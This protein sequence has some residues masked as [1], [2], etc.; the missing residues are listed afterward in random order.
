MKDL[1][2]DGID[3]FHYTRQFVEENGYDGE[4]LEL[5]TSKGVYPYKYFSDMEKFRE[6][7]LPPRK[8]YYNDLDE[9]P[10]KPLDYIT[11]Q[12][13]WEKFQLQSLGDLCHLYVKSDV[14]LLCDI[15]TKY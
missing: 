6:T 15:F 10:L 12:R 8:A 11:A 4:C 2:A 13:V 1:K 3:E 5:L 7:V 9:E 14:L